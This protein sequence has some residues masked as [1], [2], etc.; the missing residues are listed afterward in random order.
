MKFLG[1][2]YFL[3][4]LIL[5]VAISA[6]ATGLGRKI[7]DV[8]VQSKAEAS[9]SQKM[10][11]TA[12]TSSLGAAYS[13]RE[14]TTSARTVREFVN[15]DG[16]VFAVAWVGEGRPD[17]TDVFGDYYSKYKTA[18]AQSRLTQPRVR[19]HLAINTSD[20]VVKNSAMGSM[21]KGFAYI[22]NLLPSGVA[23]EDLK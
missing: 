7:N 17:F 14:I 11:I 9:S 3:P 12:K 1:F 4:V 8:T 16:V 21:M 19:N 6:G 22:P 15:A 5:S 2:P 23:A 10:K 13:V 20:I 18:L